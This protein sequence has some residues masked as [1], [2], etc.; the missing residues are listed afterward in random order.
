MVQDDEYSM[1]IKYTLADDAYVWYEFEDGEYEYTEDVEA[2]AERC[3][4]LGVSLDIYEN[5]SPSFS[6]DITVYLHYQD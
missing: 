6:Y 1:N 3:R 5:D 4:E 2:V